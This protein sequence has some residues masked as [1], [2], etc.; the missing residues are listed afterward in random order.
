MPLHL[1]QQRLGRLAQLRARLEHGTRAKPHLAL[2]E[3]EHVERVGVL[4][5]EAQPVLLELLPDRVLLRPV[6]ALHPLRKNELHALSAGV[7]GGHQP[8]RVARVDVRARHVPVLPREHSLLQPA[9]P[10][11]Q[12]RHAHLERVRADRGGDVLPLG[13]RWQRHAHAHLVPL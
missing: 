13:H 9:P 10:L 5:Q 12:P 8:G 2:D 3:L 6:G 1:L 7:V 4:G 11:E